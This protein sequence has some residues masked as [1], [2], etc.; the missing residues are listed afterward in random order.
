MVASCNRFDSELFNKLLVELSD[1]ETA[2]V[3]AIS[4]FNGD[5]LRR[6]KTNKNPTEF[7]QI[8]YSSH[9]SKISMSHKSLKIRS[10]IT[11]E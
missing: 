11:N 8:S 3:Y 10:L 4:F 5:S 7:H 1:K 6:S 9:V 2:D